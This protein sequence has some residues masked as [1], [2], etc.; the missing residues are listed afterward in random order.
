MAK[1][2]RDDIIGP[3]GLGFTQAMFKPLVSDE[4]QFGNLVD[5]VL[6]EKAEELEERVGSSVYADA[7][8]LRYLKNAERCMTAAELLR[9]RITI[10]LANVTAAGDPIR[11][12]AEQAQMKDYLAQAETWISK[13]AQGVTA[14]SP[15]GEFAC[16]ALITSHF[17]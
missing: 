13:L 6:A 4:T 16:G 11:T 15:T 12:D 9:R 2:T 10:L 14:D 17:E 5:A 1:I 7:A 8:N 3:T